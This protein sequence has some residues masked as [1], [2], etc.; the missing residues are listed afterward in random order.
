MVEGGRWQDNPNTHQ[1]IR[2]H[3]QFLP[4]AAN[5]QARS[6]STHSGWEW[7]LRPVSVTGSNS[8]HCM[9]YSHRI[10]SR[11]R[12]FPLQST[13]LS[14]NER[15]KSKE[16]LLA[17]VKL[18]HSLS[19]FTHSNSLYAILLY[20]HWYLRHSMYSSRHPSTSAFITFFTADTLQ[21]YGRIKGPR[22]T[23]LP[24]PRSCN[25]MTLLWN[26]VRWLSIDG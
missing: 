15:A 9:V 20:L 13:S 14:H 1:H 3:R 19:L 25:K 21:F 12:S 26:F 8:F 4:M 24:V 7:A 17:R 2:S 10:V 22:V 6:P 5:C 18:I 11:R 16:G 23:G